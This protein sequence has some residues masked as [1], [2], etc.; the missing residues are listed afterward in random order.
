MRTAGLPPRNSVWW[1]TYPANGMAT[2]C[3][4]DL[5]TSQVV[6]S[7]MLPNV[8]NVTN[9]LSVHPCDGAFFSTLTNIGRLTRAGA[10]AANVRLF[11]NAVSCVYDPTNNAL[12]VLTAT[13]IG[14]YSL[15]SWTANWTE[16]HGLTTPTSLDVDRSGNLLVVGSGEIKIYAG[17]S[18]SAIASGSQSG[19]ALGRFDAFGNIY[20]G[21]SS[22]LIAYKPALA[23][24][25]WQQASLPTPYLTVGDQSLWIEQDGGNVRN[26]LKLN[27]ST[28]ATEATI[29]NCMLPTA[30]PGDS[31]A[32]LQL[33]LGQS[34]PTLCTID[35]QG[36]VGR[37]GDR[38]TAYE[39]VTFDPTHDTYTTSG[40]SFGEF[41]G[42]R[43]G[44][45]RW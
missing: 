11:T 1:M 22:S 37:L 19:A 36:N 23:A 6:G 7:F 4:A 41:G 35:P 5:A 21:G 20:V 25:I 24:T 16:T 34:G 30:T 13:N 10:V 3:I 33:I 29:P 44:A 12:A 28:G 2:V 45:Y 14:E 32:G 27:L 17:L 42:G 8:Q 15:S 40:P 9:G 18:G 43:I 38:I 26:T 31:A 39:T